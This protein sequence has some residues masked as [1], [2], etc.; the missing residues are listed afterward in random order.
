MQKPLP[1]LLSLEKQGL[2]SCDSSVDA[3]LLHVVLTN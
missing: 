2:I 1:P 3:N